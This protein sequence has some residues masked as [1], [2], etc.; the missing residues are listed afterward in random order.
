[1]SWV[2][3][4]AL[5]RCNF[6]NTHLLF[7]VG[8]VLFYLYHFSV[9]GGTLQKP[10]LEIRFFFIGVSSVRQFWECNSIHVL[11]ACSHFFCIHNVELIYMPVLLL[12]GRKISEFVV[13]VL[14]HGA[15]KKKSQRRHF[16]SH[17]TLTVPT[18]NVTACISTVYQYQVFVSVSCSWCLLGAFRLVRDSVL[19]ARLW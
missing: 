4:D 8:V 14:A 15:S 13:V 16:T 11:L 18:A 10:F 7:G 1:M 17:L 19:V 5:N 12:S 2:H 3:V 6:F 9:S